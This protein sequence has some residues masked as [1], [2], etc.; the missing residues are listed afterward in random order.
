[1]IISYTETKKQPSAEVLYNLLNKVQGIL[2]GS[3]YKM[4]N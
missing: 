4:N 3:F 1:M 2:H